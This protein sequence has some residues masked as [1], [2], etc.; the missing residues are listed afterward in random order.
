MAP[1]RGQTQLHGVQQRGCP[2]KKTH[3]RPKGAKNVKAE[4]TYTDDDLQSAVQL[5]IEMEINPKGTHPYKSGRQMK[6]SGL[7]QRTYIIKN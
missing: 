4:R 1:K 2:P 5:D 3:G 7:E 6:C